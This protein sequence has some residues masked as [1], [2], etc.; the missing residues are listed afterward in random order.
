V[1]GEQ[2]SEC[3]CVNKLELPGRSLAPLYLTRPGPLLG[4]KVRP[5]KTVMM[6]GLEV[7]LRRPGYEY[8]TK[9]AS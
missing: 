4:A 6:G 2:S 8:G 7:V 3:V 9:E 1:S 5:G